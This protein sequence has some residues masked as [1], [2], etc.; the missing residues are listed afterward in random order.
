MP[1]PD[2]P[3]PADVVKPD[4]VLT[5]LA[6]ILDRVNQLAGRLDQ[7]TAANTERLNTIRDIVAAPLKERTYR[8]RRPNE[9][10]N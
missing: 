2:D 10:G 7:S 9:R 6:Q 5:L 8:A 3:K 1:R 4:P